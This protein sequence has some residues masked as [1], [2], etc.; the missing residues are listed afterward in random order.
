[1]AHASIT[2]ERIATVGG[3]FD[4][5]HMGHKDYLSLAF[6]Y[7]DFV[8]IYVSSDEYCR[9]KKKY[10]TRPFK[11]R[12]KDLE[13]FLREIK[14]QGLYKICP[15]ERLDDLKTDYLKNPDLREKIHLAIVSPEYYDFFNELNQDRINAGLKDFLI[16]VKQRSY[17]YKNEKVKDFSSSKTRKH[18]QAKQNRAEKIFEFISRDEEI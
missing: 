13:E 6:E 9:D 15:L 5:L 8:R 4:T 7:A 10:K 3:T 17:Y 18:I 11:N 12:V 2:Q 16:M 14:Y 1:M